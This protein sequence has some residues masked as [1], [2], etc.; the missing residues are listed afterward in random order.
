MITDK[1][2]ALVERLKAAESVT[3]HGAHPVQFEIDLNDPLNL[4]ADCEIVIL[5]W[6]DHA[7]LPCATKLTRGHVAE[8][9]FRPNETFICNDYEGDPITLIIQSRRSGA[10]GEDTIDDYLFDSYLYASASFPP[11]VLSVP[12]QS[13][14]GNRLMRLLAPER[15]LLHPEELWPELA[16]IAIRAAQSHCEQAGPEE[17][18]VTPNP[19]APAPPTRPELMAEFLRLTG[20]VE[21]LAMQ[22][23]ELPARTAEGHPQWQDFRDALAKLNRFGTLIIE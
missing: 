9:I 20:D 18:L 11:E 5:R 7:G 8:G 13:P 4:G 17:F 22:L 16:R 21:R 15:I 23:C 14:L 3:I 2:E 1:V 10:F 19:P 6:S 12:L